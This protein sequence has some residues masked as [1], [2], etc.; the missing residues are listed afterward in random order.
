MNL[1]RTRDGRNYLTPFLLVTTLFF[2][3][4]FAHSILDVLNKYFQDALHLT[5]TESAYIQAVVYG[6]YFLMAL[7]AGAFIRRYGYRAGVLLGL[8]MTFPFFLGC[9]FIIGCG[10]TFLETSANPYVTVLG[11]P[12]HSEQRIN[13]SQSF[14]GLG[15]IIGP[16]TGSYFLFNDKDQSPDISMPYLLIGIV[17]MVVALLFSRVRLPEITPEEDELTQAEEAALEAEGDHNHSDL[18]VLLRNGAFLFGWVGIFVY[19]AAQTG[20]NSFFINYA[21]ENAGINSADASLILGVG[22]MGLFFAGRMLGS[23]IMQYIRAE[24]LLAILALVAAHC[25]MLVVASP[26]RVGFT[27]LLIVYFCESIM[28]PTIFALALRGL[29]RRTKIASSLLIMGIV[30]GAVAPVLMGLIADHSSMAYGFIV[31]LVCFF[32]IAAYGGFVVRRSARAQ[33]RH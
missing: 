27:A 23:W 14:N 33:H 13:F 18:H 21:V 25:S 20:V 15:W 29:G 31:P 9:L 22:G 16:V 6:G 11:E 30:G 5:K 2:L 19:V 28:F 12:E 32:I 26:G 4:G 24:R 8:V 17:V 10:L 7:P 3:W 1:V